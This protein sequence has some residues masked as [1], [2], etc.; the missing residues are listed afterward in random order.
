M[1]G[2]GDR[3]CEKNGKISSCILN[4]IK[5]GIVRKMDLQGRIPMVLRIPNSMVLLE[6]ENTKKYRSSCK[7]FKSSSKTYKTSTKNA[8]H[9]QKNA[10]HRK[11]NSCRWPKKKKNAIH[12][13]KNASQQLQKCKS[14]KK[15]QVINKQKYKSPEKK[16]KS[17]QKIQVISML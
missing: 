13:T 14:L 17:V 6:T 12:Q 16:C 10:S 8:S 3:Y 5:N 9:R 11:K 15:I 2:L 7:K 1:T 4:G